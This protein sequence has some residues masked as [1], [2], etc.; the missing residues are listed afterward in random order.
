VRARE[1]A[2]EGI[3]W[4]LR[5]RHRVADRLVLSKVR[6]LFGT[7]LDFAISA[8]APIAADVLD[9]FNAA[10]VRVLEAYGMT[11]TTAAG[12]INTLDEWRVGKVGRPLPP[13]AVRL[14]GDGEILM[15]GPHVFSGYFKDPGATAETI[16][17]GWLRTG[18]LGTIDDDGFLAISGRK[19]EII[20]TSSGKNITPTNIENALRED[21]W[22]SEAVVYGDNRPYL[23][24]L[25]TIDPDE[26]PALAE[27]AGVEAEVVAMARDQRVRAEIQRVIDAANERFARI[28]QIKRFEILPHDLTQEAGEL[29][30]TLKVKRRI[31]YQRY[32]DVFERLYA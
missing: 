9:F 30:P 6:E 28:E 24:A 25:I 2:G 17:D 3:G 1:D 19:K 26:V 8:A 14:A 13:G 18:D 5:R 32:A 4:L 21:R 7:R 27:E 22:I 23:V 12:A 11:E 31:V 20:I 10:G 15:S 16:V 29:T